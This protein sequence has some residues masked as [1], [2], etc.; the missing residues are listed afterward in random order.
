MHDSLSASWRRTRTVAA[1][2]I[3]LTAATGCQFK[4]GP[5][6]R[7]W[8]DAVEPLRHSL[9]MDGYRLDYID[10]GRG[11]PVLLV[12]GFADSTYCFHANFKPLVDAGFR[13]IAIDLPGLGR[14]EA[15]PE[16]FVYSIENLAGETLKF[17]DRLG[18]GRFAIAGSSMGGGIALFLA[19][20]QPERVVRV[21]A[22]DP[23]CFSLAGVRWMP[24]A[25]NQ[26]LSKAA[27]SL[28]TP[29][30]VDL[31]LHDVFWDSSQVNSAVV[32]EYS[33]PLAKPGYRNLLRRLIHEYF[34]AEFDAMTE[35]YDTIK[36]PTLLIWGEN[37]RW[38]PPEFGPRLQRL[39]PDAQLTFAPKCGHLPHQERP[40]IV[41]PLL[42]EFL[43]R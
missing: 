36:S 27:L 42:I 19:E 13:A 34:S 10:S 40:D 29:L 1:V 24:L 9:Q 15:P 30:T 18:L 16:P 33:R 26:T 37:D 31:A 5:G 11:D 23:A 21:I 38:V 17:A 22:F 28:A 35:H 14:S 20:R 6:D 32:D 3:L 25:Q 43:K 8:N 41:N 7:Q 4:A 12:H 39:I 2:L